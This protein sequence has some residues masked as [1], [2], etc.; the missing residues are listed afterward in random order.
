MACSAFEGTQA[1]RSL[2]RSAISQGALV[3]AGFKGGL[4]APALNTLVHRV[5]VLSMA[6]HVSKQPSVTLR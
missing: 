1:R 5:S 2:D 4:G 6:H 3:E